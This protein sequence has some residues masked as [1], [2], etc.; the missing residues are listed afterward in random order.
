MPL[1]DDLS[2]LEFEA[3]MT[4]AFEKHEDYHNVRQTPKTGDKGRDI[5]MRETVNGHERAVVVECKHKEQVSRGEVQKLHSAIVSFDEYLGPKRG[6][7]VTS[8]RF[9]PQAKE[10]AEHLRENVDGTAIELVDGRQLREI[11]DILGM[12][13]RNGNFQLI[14]E[15]T[16]PP[17][18]PAGDIETPIGEQFDTIANIDAHERPASESTILFQ[19]VVSI[20]AQTDTRCETPSSGKVLR[21]GSK[22]DEFLLDGTKTPPARVEDSVRGL[23][24]S[25]APKMVPLAE[26]RDTERVSETTDE[27]F[28]QSETDYKEWTVE[29]LQSKYAETIPYTGDNNV[30]YS[31]DCVPD[32]SDI[33]ITELTAMR[34]PRVRSQIRLQEHDYILE[35]D[36]AGATRHMI[37]NDL[38]HCVHCGWSWLRLTYCDNCG[39]IACWRH[40]KTERLNGEPICTGCAVTARFGLRKRYFFDEANRDAFRETYNAMAPARKVRE[41]WPWIATATLVLIGLLVILLI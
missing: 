37:E 25:D 13:L 7:F 6:M 39:A 1:L 30:D 28:A 21:Q 22:Q 16:L 38:G 29:H 26:W 10:H 18:D 24:T 32:S 19:P 4:T 17:V 2:G 20:Q 33:S 12:D 31:E 41:N 27:Q 40:T 5:L 3:T 14:G 34:V 11:G 23:L 8:G 15:Q 35:Y 9:S 36:A